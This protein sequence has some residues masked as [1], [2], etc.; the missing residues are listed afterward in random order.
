MMLEAREAAC[1]VTGTEECPDPGWAFL[2]GTEFHLACNAV[3]PNDEP[4]EEFPIRAGGC[5]DWIQKVIVIH[6]DFFWVELV[7][8]NIWQISCHEMLHAI[9]PEENNHESDWVWRGEDSMLRRCNEK[10]HD[11]ERPDSSAIPPG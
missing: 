7:G 10:Y 1:D 2:N 9:Y 11:E 4:T 8:L 3:G 5:Y 6:D